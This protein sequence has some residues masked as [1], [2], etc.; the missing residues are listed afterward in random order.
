M[1]PLRTLTVAIAASLASACTMIP[2]YQRPVAPVPANFPNAPQAAEATPA[3]AIIW[4]DYFANAQLRDVI[5]LALANNRDL[6]VAALNI[7]Q[8]RAQ[9]GATVSAPAWRR[10]ADAISCARAAPAAARA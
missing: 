2:E 3:D 9:Y 4:R 5:A 1:S 8:A 10:S 6:R 7:E